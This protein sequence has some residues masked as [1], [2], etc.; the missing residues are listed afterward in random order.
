MKFICEF[1]FNVYNKLEFAMEKSTTDTP[2]VGTG[3]SIVIGS[4]RY[5]AEVVKVN[6]PKEIE[7]LENKVKCNDY[8]A[9]DYT[10]LKGQYDSKIPQIFTLRKNGRWVLKGQ[11]L[12]NGIGLY[13]SH[14]HYIDPSF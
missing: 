4:D 1:L 3:C 6:S 12:W 13:W 2:K 7:V 8:Y 11:N 9:G 5:A 10:I 14:T